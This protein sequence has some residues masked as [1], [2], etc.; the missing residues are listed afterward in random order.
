MT[1][2][3]VTGGAGFIGSHLVEALVAEGHSVRV[4]DNFSTGSLANLAAVRDRVEVVPGD[5]GERDT[6][7]AAMQDVELVFHQAALSSVPHSV[8]DPL[9]THQA[10][11]S[12]T[13]HVLVAAHEARVR[14]VIYGSS[15]SAYGDANPG[16]RAENEPLQPISPYAVAK[17]T[18]EFYCT[19]FTAVHGLETVRLRTF[20]VYGPRQS[21]AGPYAAVIPRF[22]EAM[23]AGK[24]PVI[25]GDGKQTRDFTY[26]D[27]VVQAN[28]LAAAARR[29]SGRVYNIGSGRATPVLE[30][31]E[32]INRLLGTA[33]R[34][35]YSPPRP[36]D[37]RHNQ[38]DI[39]R[40]QADLGYLPCTDLDQ[41]LRRCLAHDAAPCKGPKH[42]R[43]PVCPVA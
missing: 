43:K 25:H 42:A 1:A 36:G 20:N 17:L 23:R 2:C 5:L 8:V 26:V 11:A 27:D 14:R 37:L 38:A 24:R 19:A 7:Q 34:P 32:R 40:A 35:I 16:P 41:G 28:L 21:S 33:L 29:V 9:S 3:L 18:G 12:G 22:L 39:A 10:C 15:S 13:L 6:V 4:L 30:V 31:V